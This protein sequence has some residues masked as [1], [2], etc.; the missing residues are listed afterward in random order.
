MVSSRIRATWTG[1]VIG[2][3]VSTFNASGGGIPTF[4]EA[5]AL[6]A[7]VHDFYAAI[8]NNIPDGVTISVDPIVEVFN[9]LSGE[10]VSE[11]VMTATPA[12]VVGTGAPN[13][14]AGV[15]GR[16]R[17]RTSGIRNGRRVVGTTFI[18]PMVTAAYDEDGTFG[19]PTI[20]QFTTAGGNLISDFNLAGHDLVVWSRPSQAGVNDGQ[21]SPVTQAFTP[22]QVA[23]LRTRK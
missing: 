9:E 23:W 1:G 8:A 19:A 7:A 20:T 17:W 22:D 6:G 15:G 12:D 18:V 13:H 3:G 14:A 21:I 11:V 16:I 10:L 4:A 5:D 2:T